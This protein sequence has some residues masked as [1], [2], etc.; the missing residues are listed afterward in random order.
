MLTPRTALL[1]GVLTLGFAWLSAG[2]ASAQNDPKFQKVKFL[3]GDGVELRGSWYAGQRNA[4]VI[5]VLTELGEDSSKI[6]YRALA[7]TLHK[8]GFSVLLFDFRGTGG[9]TQVG[10]GGLFLAQPINKLANVDNTGALDFTKFPEAYHPVL[11]N[12][13][14]AAKAF[15]DLKND[16][17]DCNSS[18]LVLIGAQRGATLG[19]LWLKSEFYRFKLIPR[20]VQLGI[21]GGPDINNPQGRNVMACIFLSI[22]YKLGKVQNAQPIGRLVE[23]TG[24]KWLVPMVFVHNSNDENDTKFTEFCAKKAKVDGDKRYDATGAVGIKGAAGL[25]GADLLK[26]SLTTQSEIVKYLDNLKDQAKGNP[27]ISHDFQKTQYIWFAPPSLRV[28]ANQGQPTFNFIDYL[29]FVNLP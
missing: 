9:S 1:A 27:W 14:A 8:K 18:S 7:D 29:R 22:S 13:I 11:V 25:Q 3:T 16:A 17:S 26:K 21:Q 20:N 5:L 19:A 6:E 24:K 28:L 23:S 10:N 12:D 15:V 4:P 2:P